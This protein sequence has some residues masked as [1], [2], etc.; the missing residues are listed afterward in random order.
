MSERARAHAQGM[1]MV[2]IC[3]CAQTHLERRFQGGLPLSPKLTNPSTLNAKRYTWSAASK[4]A[5]LSV[6]S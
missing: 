5:S 1:C 6:L 4:A 3:A 2:C